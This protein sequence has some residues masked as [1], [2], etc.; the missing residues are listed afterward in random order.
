MENLPVS[1]AKIRIPLRR[2]ELVSRTRLM[3][4][5]YEQFERKLLL[6][7][8]PP[9]YGKT[10]LL[11]DMANNSDIPVCWLSLDALDREPQRFLVYLISAIAEKFPDFGRDSF[12]AL[13]NMT[14]FEQDGERLLVTI[15]NEIAA[16]INDHFYLVLDDFHLV[17]DVLIIRQIVSR[18]LHLAGENVHLI[19]ATRNLPDLPDTPL[20]IVRNQVGGLGFE[21]LSFRSEEIQQLFLQNKGQELSA[22]DAE[23][24]VKETEGWIAAIHL[25]GGRPGQLPQ[26]HP[27]RSTRE[28]FGFFSREV[29]G[30]QSEEMRRFLMM[31]SFLDT[32]DVPLCV[33][34]LAPLLTDTELD[35]PSLFSAAQ[36]NNLYSV[37]L[38]DDGRWMRYHHLFQHFLKS[39]L[40]YDEPALAWH[41]QQNLARAYEKSQSWEEALQVYATL[42]DHENLVR[43]LGQAGQIF[44]R[45]GRILTLTSWLERL[46]TR[47]V[48][49]QP[50]LMS[51]QGA[52]LVVRGDLHQALDLFNRAETR[53]QEARDF[54]GLMLTLV[55]RA[56][57]NHHLGR[58]DS[59]LEDADRALQVTIETPQDLTPRVAF[60]EAQ[61]FKGLAYL[62]LGRLQ[63]ALFWLKE[64]LQSWK[65]LGSASNISVIE[66]E[67]GV[68]S[69]R[70]G[71]TEAA[72]RYYASALKAWEN[73][74]NSGWKARLLNNL[75]LLYHLT[76]RLEDAYPLLQKA[77]KSAEQGGYVRFQTNALISLGDILTDLQDLETARGYYEQALTLATNLGDSPLI[78]YASLGEARL[79]RLAGEVSKSMEDLR[80]IEASQITI[81][82]YERVLFNLE[83]GC[84]LLERGEPAQAIQLFTE[85]LNLMGTGAS[86]EKS[87]LQ[88]WLASAWFEDDPEAAVGKLGGL[89]P[90]EKEWQKPTPIMIHAGRAGLWLESKGYYPFQDQTL[91]RFFD[92]AAQIRL[93][94]PAVYNR[95]RKDSQQ[96]PLQAPTLE[97]NTFGP[98]Q[99]KVDGRLVGIPEWQTREARDMFVFL[100]QSRP[101]TKEQIGLEFWPDISAARLKMRFKVNMY[102]IRHALGQEIVLFDGENYFFNRTMNYWWDREA[103]DQ[104][105]DAAIKSKSRREKSERLQKALRL[106]KGLYLEDI[107]AA[108]A[109]HEQSRYKEIVIRK[110]IEL[111]EIKF[112]EGDY[113]ACMDTARQALAF[114]HILEAAH[115][116]IIQAYAALHDPAGMARQYEL[117]RQE[118]DDELGML[119]SSEIIALYEALLREV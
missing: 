3:E 13:E 107:D 114:D 58:Y 108:W 63:E 117:Y 88:L 62:G 36:N 77:L 28:L 45:K 2:R 11:I 105:L 73:A 26:L 27:L 59:V 52:V 116:L 98:L 34:V 69:R 74:G 31:T 20:M 84:G 15:S 43:V 103:F 85:T 25:T 33:E 72:A 54:P 4:L 83:Q 92:Q 66:T 10:S 112:A 46:P 47:L 89:L 106:V 55:R 61:R 65:E 44:I 110:H 16:R 24:L 14:S 35:W 9:G 75:A 87:A 97:I 76:G 48:Y 56:S 94:M 49:S 68:V 95:I 38:G 119:P 5:L 64:A 12:A 57:A 81:G 67:L 42:D 115:R 39:K 70:L 109:V 23:A 93:Q 99:V 8:A 104:T 78:F 118:L 96:T 60:A 100:L 79:H 6:I 90:S 19:V 7:D 113:Q 32:F 18:F 71:D 50:E 101:M 21:E 1:K 29:L 82:L 53:Q 111:A 37:P 102:R 17:D 51:L 40:Q 86:Q 80:L 41:I 91:N 30:R 22:E